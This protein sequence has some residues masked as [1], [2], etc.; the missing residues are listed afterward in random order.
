VGSGGRAEGVDHHGDDERE[1]E[2]H[3]P[4]SRVVEPAAADRER[5]DHGPGAEEDEQ[6][7]AERLREETRAEGGFCRRAGH[8]GLGRRTAPSEGKCRTVVLVPPR[9]PHTGRTVALLVAVRGLSGTVYPPGTEVFT[10]G[11]GAEVEAFVGGDWIP[12]RWWEFAEP[13][14]SPAGAG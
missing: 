8:D 14:I 2:R 7:R 5:R 10:S 1:R 11:Q 13:P 4:Q 9:T 6:A 3:H 12:L